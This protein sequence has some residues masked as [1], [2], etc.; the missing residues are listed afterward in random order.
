MC[1][2]N[3]RHGYFTPLTFL[4]VRFGSLLLVSA[5]F[6][7]VGLFAPVPVA[8]EQRVARRGADGRVAARLEYGRH[9][10]VDQPAEVA[11][12]VAARGVLLLLL[13]MVQLIGLI[14]GRRLERRLCGRWQV[15]QRPPD[16][17][18][19][20]Q[21]RGHGVLRRMRSLLTRVVMMVMV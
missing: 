15:L 19:A 10:E 2:Y 14:V 11:R 18:A 9:L 6:R 4:T 12:L 8:A 7:R 1:K 13:L 17:M 16:L 3:K 21:R 20:G 5:G